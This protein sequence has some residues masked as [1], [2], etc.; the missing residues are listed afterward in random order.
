MLADE[1]MHV[2]HRD[3]LIGSVAAAIATGISFLAQMAM[4]SAIFGGRDDD[5]GGGNAS[6]PC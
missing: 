4:F 5:D 3:I 1:M 6:V 2:R